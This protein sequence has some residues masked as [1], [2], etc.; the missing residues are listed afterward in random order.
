MRQ[1]NASHKQQTLSC[2][3]SLYP[4]SIRMKD[5]E[6]WGAGSRWSNMQ[7]SACL[8]F[9]VKK[10]IYLQSVLLLGVGLASRRK[11]RRRRIS[12]AESAL[13]SSSV[14]LL[15]ENSQVLK[16]LDIG[17]AIAFPSYKFHVNY[18]IHFFFYIT[19]ILISTIV[20]IFLI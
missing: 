8:R 16:N 9:L 20:S 5:A 2:S 13:L 4:V 1:R 15:N 12:R 18:L 19:C 7:R 17:N 11:E 14:L 3:W 6:P 10:R